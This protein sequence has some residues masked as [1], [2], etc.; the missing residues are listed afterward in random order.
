MKFDYQARTTE[1]R[2]QTGVVEASSREAAFNVLKTYGLYV[3]ALE[4]F[5]N[6]PFYAKKMS[7]FNRTSKKDIVAFSRQVSIMFK[8][9]VPIIETF[10]A[11]S[12]QTKKSDL[13]EKISKISE[14]VEGGNSL[15]KAF[16]IYPNLFSSFY[17]NMIKAGE[18]S[19]KLSEVFSYLADYLEK[20][21]SF[22]SKIKGAMIYPAFVLIVFIGVVVLIM[23][24]VIPQLAEVLKSSGTELPLLTKIVIG[25]SDFMKEQWLILILIVAAIV[26]GA[27]KFTKS[28][29]GKEIIDET[30]MRTPIIKNFFLKMYLARFA[31]NLST[32][33]SGGL[34]IATALEITGEVVGT[35]VYKRIIL[36]TRDRVKRG[37][38]I[39]SSLER[40]PELISPLFYQMVMVGEKTGTL[41]ESLINVIGFYQAD[42]ERSID[43]FIR[44]LEP[45]FIIALAAVVAG[46][47]G[48]V[49][50]P[51]YSGGVLGG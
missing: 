10:K 24:Y 26:F 17:I 44:L 4:E 27:Y 6:A 43:S 34:P 22:N 29:G 15:S 31:M 35:S 40:Y 51:L 12:Q 21:Q 2:I 36:E 5:S 18:A 39:S 42:V 47:M 9:N 49:L 14:E 19:G 23:T 37:E 46:L 1:G 38:A 16:S 45:I 25:A 32:L 8:S 7:L 3:T 33:I 20:Q 50:L 41:D 28:R 11:I 30:I 13:K 48:A